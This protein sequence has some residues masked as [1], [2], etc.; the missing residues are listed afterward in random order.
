MPQLESDLEL[1]LAAINSN[2]VET[3][4]AAAL[5]PLDAGPIDSAI[6]RWIESNSLPGGPAGLPVCVLWLLAGDLDHS[7]R[8][9]QQSETPLGSFLHGV[10]HR[11]EF[12]FSNAKYWFRRVGDDQSI[13]TMVRQCDERSGGVYQ[14]PTSFVDRCERAVD[15]GQTRDKTADLISAQ[16]TEWQGLMKAAIDQS[17]PS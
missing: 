5:P 2:L 3:I 12:D 15:G 11:R 13:A 9:S 7:H 8:I 17:P 6:V 16:W 4:T 10:M 14:N 1:S